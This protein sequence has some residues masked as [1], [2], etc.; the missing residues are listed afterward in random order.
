MMRMDDVVTSSSVPLGNGYSEKYT[1]CDA[2]YQLKLRTLVETLH[3]EQ[4]H[5]NVEC[6][7]CSGVC[8]VAGED[9]DL[10][11]SHCCNQ[12]GGTLTTR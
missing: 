9:L 7:Q 4:N 6:N 12:R 3:F 10:A 2:I 8:S 5:G 1:V 11:V